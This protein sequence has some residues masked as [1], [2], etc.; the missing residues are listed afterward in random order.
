MDQKNQVLIKKL[1]PSVLHLSTPP[2]NSLNII[3]IIDYTF[4]KAKMKDS[5]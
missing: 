5:F 4:F 3:K 1:K 2:K